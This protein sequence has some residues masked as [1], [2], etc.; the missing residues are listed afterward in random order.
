MTGGLLEIGE[1]I[2]ATSERRLE[3]VS[4]NIANASTA[5]FKKE[6]TFATTLSMLQPSDDARD[7]KQTFTDFSQGA[8]RMTG[9]PFDLAISGAGFFKVRSGEQILLTR[10]G[11]F[12]LASNGQ[13]L[14]A[15]GMILQTASGEDL[16]VTD[17][18]AEILADGVVLEHRLPVARIGLFE[19]T[20]PASL[21][22]VGAAMFFVD[23]TQTSE[24]ETPSL[25]QGMVE[26][27]N[28][29]MA[30]EMVGM[31]EALRSAEIGSRIVQ[32]YDSLVDKSISTFGRGAT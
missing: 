8:L 3:V 17:P 24:V 31:M 12:E 2:L 4:K 28:V 20:E 13:L 6:E 10:N 21:Q 27:A 18:E 32:T 26:A 29:E 19:P 30:G 1:M 7:A 15:Q 22:A 5:G 16:V 11:E 14:N 9:R 23:P 25:R